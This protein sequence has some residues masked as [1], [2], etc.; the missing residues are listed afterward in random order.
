MIEWE[1]YTQ[2]NTFRLFIHLL[3][4]SNHEEDKWR[5]IE[6]KRGQRITSVSKLS[7]DLGVSIRSIRTC[8]R[9]LENTG[10]LTI[11]TTNRFTLITINN[12]EKYQ[13]REVDDKQADKP[14][15]QQ[16]DK[17]TDN[18]QEVKK[19]RR[20]ETYV[21]RSETE[22]LFN[23]IDEMCVKY[24]IDNCINKKSLDIIVERYLGKIRMKVEM[25][26]CMSWIIEKG[27]KMITAQRIGNW[28]KKA[29]EIQ[30][31]DSNKFLAGEHKKGDEKSKEINNDGME[32]VS[33][34]SKRLLSRSK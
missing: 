31:R 6:V 10:E 27:H 33:E 3:L 18:K 22:S 28:F 24:K 23:S 29:Q 21:C 12:Y 5:G 2:G 14:T 11:E 34:I 30:K 13:L 17:P 9:Q 8:L 7:G 25:Q 16:S 15:A 19:L 20:K 32:S 26:H 4:I 1:W